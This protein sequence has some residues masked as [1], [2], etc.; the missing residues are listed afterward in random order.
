MYDRLAVPRFASVA[1]EL[2]RCT[3]NN[4]NVIKKKKHDENSLN[5]FEHLK[6]GDCRRK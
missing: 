1:S 3:Q 2:S 5:G 6:K 4:L